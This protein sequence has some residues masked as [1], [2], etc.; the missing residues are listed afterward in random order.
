MSVSFAVGPLFASLAFRA[1]MSVEA[2]VYMQS[3]KPKDVRSV[4][5]FTKK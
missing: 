1:C 3:A 2:A 4:V 5:I